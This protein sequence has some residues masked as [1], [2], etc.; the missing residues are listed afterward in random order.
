M[1]RDV[2]EILNMVK[3]GVLSPEQGKQFMQTMNQ[4]RHLSINEDNLVQE[5]REDYHMSEMHNNFV[6]KSVVLDKPG[7][8]SD[9]KVST[10]KLSDP[11]EKEVQI[12]VKAFSLNFGDVLCVKGLYPT[13]PEYPFTPGFEISGVVVKTGVGVTRF[14]KGDE[15]IGLMGDRLGGQ[16]LIVNTDESFVV[17]KP[18]NITHEEACSFP[19]VYLTMQHVFDKARI[20]KGEKILIQTATGGTGLIAVQ[21]ALLQGA[22]VYATAGSEEKLDYLRKMGIKHLINYRQDD[23]SKKILEM[24]DG[25]GVDV[26]INTLSGDA[27]QK[28]LEILA[29]QGRYLE[30]AMTGLKSAKH[31]DLSHLV[32]NQTLYSVDMR[33]LMLSKKQDTIKYLDRMYE[34]LEKGHVKPTI[35]KVFSFS[36]I[37]K[38]YRYL[39]DRKNIGKVVVKATRSYWDYHIKK[40]LNDEK[41]VEDRNEMVVNQQNEVAIIGMSC[42]LPDAKN[43]DEFWYNLAKGASAIKEVPKE[44]WNS[45]IYYDPDVEKLDKT[46]CKW[47][48]FLG[49]ID[50]FDNLFFNMSGKEAELS[51]PQQRLL[52]EESWNALEDAGYAN[53]S[54]SNKKCS[55]FVGISNGDY[56]D[57]MNELGIQKEAQS[58]W[59]NH[60]SVSAA[61]ISYFLNLKGASVAVDT[62]C[63]SALVSLHMGC[64][65]IASGE[66]ELVLT[67][68]AFINV[69]PKFFIASSNANM[70]SPEGKSAAFDNNANGF[71]PGEGVVMFVLKSLDAALQDGD[72]VYGVIKS[73]GINQ[74]GKTNGIT[75]PSTLSQMELEQSVYQKANINPET[76]TYVETHGTGTKLGD[77]IEI[78]ALT[79]SFR[80]YTNK[81]GYCAI[82]SVKTNIGHAATAAGGASLAKV[83]LS[84]RHKQ[85]PPSLNF[86]TPNEHIDFVNSPFYVN[87]ELKDWEVKTGEK[88]RAAISS[89]GFSGTN[90][91][92][93]IEEP[94]QKVISNSIKSWYFVP[95]S[96]RNER[97]LKQQLQRLRKWLEKESTYSIGDICYT[98]L[99]GRKH[100]AVRSA[101]LV[102]N[103]A[104]LKQNLDDLC[105]D[106]NISNYIIFD[107]KKSSDEKNTLVKATGERLIREFKEGNVKEENYKEKLWSLIE[108]YVKGY[109][110]DWKKFYE[111]SNYQRLSLPTYPFSYSRFWLDEA[112]QKTGEGTI[113]NDT[114]FQRSWPHP[115]IEKN[116]SS[117]EEYKFTTQMTGDEFY[118]SDHMINNEKVLPGVAY[119]EMVRA[120]GE[121][122]GKRNV[123]KIKNLVWQS[124]IKIDSSP[125]N[126]H[127]KLQQNKTDIQ[128][129]VFSEENETKITHNYGSILFGDSELKAEK[130]NIDSVMQRCEKLIEGCEIYNLI[131]QRNLYLGTSFQVIQ[132][133]FGNKQEFVSIIKIPQKLIDGSK[134]FKLHPSLMDGA[135][136]T[137][138]LGM[139]YKELYVPFSIGELEIFENLQTAYYVYAICTKETEGKLA[140]FDVYI[141][142]EM[143]EVLV[144]I[145]DFIAKPFVNPKNISAPL[146]FKSVWEPIKK[147]SEKEKDLEKVIIFDED[148][149]IWNSIRGNCS[150]A[151]LVK[152]GN[153]YKEISDQMYVIDPRC[154]SDYVKLIETLKE[155]DLFPR[156]IVYLWTNRSVKQ[157]F[158]KIEEE[159]KRGIYS[160]F[161]L[162]KA[163]TV[164]PLKEKLQFIYTYSRQSGISEPIQAALSGFFKVASSENNKFIW[165]SIALESHLKPDILDSVLAE[166]KANAQ[167]SEV[168][169]V[170]GQRL[171]K[172]IRE[173]EFKEE[174]NRI[175]PWKQKG[176]YLITGGL[177]GIGFLLA[178]YL[179]KEFKAKLVLVGRVGL[180]SDKKEKIEELISY[181]AEVIYVQADVSNRQEVEKL[182]TETKEKYY[183]IHGILHCAGIVHDALIQKKNSEQVTQV[184]APKIWGTIWLD[185]ATKNEKLDLFVLFSS[186]AAVIGNIGQSDY[187]YANAFMDEFSNWR[188]Q[189]VGISHRFGKTISINW[190]L[191]KEGGMKLDAP[192]EKLMNETLGLKP[193][194]TEN[195]IYALEQGLIHS[196][197]HLVV[198]QGERG[199]MRKLVG[200]MEGS[201]NYKEN[202]AVDQLVEGITQDENSVIEKLE[203][204]LLSIVANILKIN[205]QDIYL[206]EEMS[207]FGFDSLSLTDFSNKV[208]EKFNI[209]IVPA[210]LFEYSRLDSV[211]EYLIEEYRE[212]IVQYYTEQRIKTECILSEECINSTVQLPE[213]VKREYIVTEDL[214]REEGITGIQE[215]PMKKLEPIAI[216]GMSGIMPQ[217]KDLNIFWEHLLKE[218][219][220]IS[221][222][223]T[224][225]WDWKKLYGEPIS[226]SNKTNI[227]WGGFMDEI[228]KFDSLFFGISP[229]EA[230]L[231]DPQQRIVMENIWKTIE[232]A[233]YKASDL[234][235]TRT[236]VFMGVSS[237]DYGDLQTQNEIQAQTSTG[238]SHCILT[239]RIS[240]LLNLHGPSEPIDTAC[241]SSLVAVHRAVEQIQNGECELAIAG[242]VN[243]IASPTLYLSFNKAGM[244]CQDGRCKTFDKDANGYVRGEGVGTLLLKPLSRAEA[245]G[246]HIYGV[247][248]GSAVNHGG[249]ANSLTAPNPNAQADLITHAWKKAKVD[250]TTAS[251]I[252]AHGT[253]TALGDPIEING[254]RKAFNQLY[255]EWDKPIEEKKCGIGSVKTNIGHIEAAAGIAGICKVLLAMK[256]KMLPASIHYKEINPYIK[257]EGS[258]F[259][260]V[261][262]TTPWNQIRDENN[263]PIPRRAGISSFGF[264]G[265]NAHI[266]IE[267]YQKTINKHE[268]VTNEPQIIVLSAKNEKCLKEYAANLVTSI[269]EE[270]SLEDIAYT[271]QL[272]R[273]S[274]E[275]R[276]A[277]I[278]SNKKELKEKLIQYCEGYKEIPHLYHGT[279]T[280][281][282]EKWIQKE[283]RSQNYIKA[284]IKEK[285]YMELSQ[286]WIAGAEVDWNLLHSRRSPKRIS[287]ATYPFERVGHWVSDCK[288]GYVFAKQEIEKMNRYSLIDRNISTL[289]ETKFVKSL[290]Q[291]VFYLKDHVVHGRKVLPGVVYLEMAYTAGTL[292]TE[293]S[294]KKI[295]NISWTKPIVMEDDSKRDIYIKFNN[296]MENIGYKI[297]S[298]QSDNKKTIHSQGQLELGSEDSV[299]KQEFVDLVNIREKCME[300]KEGEECYQLFQKMGLTYGK[301]FKGIK[302]LYHNKNECLAYIELPKF[303]MESEEDF[304]LHPS[305]MDS[306][307]QSVI[308]ILGHKQLKTLYLPVGISEL[309]V[310][311]KLPSNCYAYI[312]ICNE[313]TSSGSYT[314]DIKITDETG[315]VIININELLIYPFQR[316][317]NFITTKSEHSKESVIMDILQKVENGELQFDEANMLMEEWLHV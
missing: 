313:S 29:P 282:Q 285:D 185:D 5:R 316:K 88:R 91:H 14:K 50:Q 286:L 220:L 204:D 126:I 259:Y 275:E 92:V 222:I 114:C 277:I 177:G 97:A 27:I 234:S 1:K 90:A 16:S 21:M 123:N 23:F 224:D 181:G 106:K 175:L 139:G 209:D 147:E 164:E 85:I 98:L 99:M 116:S 68:G 144:K 131:A 211:V 80:K 248:K 265:V 65:S 272:G 152:K 297:Y 110:L 143:G 287:L 72:H 151:I 59:G 93:V 56:V 162:T 163:L 148:E 176:V 103:I 83:L 166:L 38:A 167:S 251:Y 309:E 256:N 315:K 45:K 31:I 11:A 262:K 261:D 243:V 191:W 235:G 84:L 180:S 129:D 198:L 264:G 101:L 34:V 17:K 193:L 26:L 128:Y 146:Y 304:V 24:T 20:K 122:I 52:L 75:A 111:D 293:K 165:Q 237:S 102:R 247:I 145:K 210:I 258:P 87:S 270:Y 117:I 245:D 62:A 8:I 227:K 82:G 150:S 58:F 273:E 219:D 208:N 317:A 263:Q 231:M 133:M 288:V 142:D 137:A 215:E 195:G 246:N 192:M 200:D 199:K 298:M 161:A 249:R 312:T 108:F 159:L 252:E 115:L 35:D 267:E 214:D 154:E 274:M 314:F 271:L 250:P 60:N 9:I 76:I 188:E 205:Q 303:I 36:E 194:H 301:S 238:M 41:C 290:E 89:F 255:K 260:I 81:K 218:K 183:K 47:G 278:V 307:I 54:I 74:D 311:D 124:P 244:L 112:N 44:R 295:T 86:Q 203:Q 73:S 3:E 127:I 120:A 196:E 207:E 230:E 184:L 71:V 296:D 189:L 95:F 170:N 134:E 136:Q 206:D 12:L 228:D 63:S 225:R 190:P 18:K 299:N 138:L 67:G 302:K 266:V 39:E 157:N 268:N 33:K 77:P 283:G 10:I 125:K 61:R 242:G 226:G 186:I 279:V 43:K 292:A 239:N 64:Q 241:S 40:M 276:I 19:I 310:L 155:K 107:C 229:K 217:S 119:I 169:Y 7:N 236:G 104:E 179:A 32:N 172:S 294:V 109:Q 66:S 281:Q 141:L 182:I 306:V 6:H 308:G 160:V 300:S 28:G 212:Q 280:V 253:G 197:K 113:K 13:M 78:E 25:N 240:Y 79:N 130:I 94:P 105:E 132:E 70:L 46:N 201:N 221:E 149:E 15:V 202:Y 135:L 53:D 42:R 121:L 49:D 55:V 168:S 51:D 48:G 69:T 171:V 173:F 213:L 187:A 2:K 284:R 140:K 269:Q 216:I 233:G 291:D 100:F 223:P 30:I 174:E 156:H 254:L 118:L 289:V 37:Q 305:L 153:Y 158:E 4:Q 22:E 96:A 232:D 178:Q 257:L 57:K